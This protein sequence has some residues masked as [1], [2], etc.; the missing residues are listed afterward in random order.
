MTFDPISVALE[1]GGKV[2]DRIWPNPTEAAAAK[3]E[4]LKMQQSGE[5]AKLTADTEIA[6]GQ[7]AV[8]QVEAASS[9]IFVAGGRPFVIWICGLSLGYSALFE[10]LLRFVAMVIY[11]YT[12][13]FP[14]LDTMLTGQILFGLLGLGAMR[15]YDKKQ[16]TSS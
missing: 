4:L 16:G 10:P 2:I 13:A 7:L 14:V 9:S 15:S 3:L 12:G 11:N 6:K 8:N 1:I 5:L